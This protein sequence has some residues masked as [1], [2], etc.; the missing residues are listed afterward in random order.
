MITLSAGGWRAAVLPHVG[1]AIGRLDWR[2]RPVFRPAPE[3]TTN[4]LETG[5]FPLVPYANRID[6]GRFRW[7]GRDID[8][9][10]TPGFEPH[11]LHGQGWRE[12]WD[13][14]EVDGASVRLVLR[15]PAGAWPW[16]WAAEQS[17]RLSEAGLRIDLTVT[18]KDAAPMPAGLGLHPY[19]ATAAGD[20]VRL[21][22]TSVWVGATLIPDR[23][24]PPGA[25]LD[26]ADGLE[27][28]AAPF[29][30]HAYD[31]WTGV[32]EIAGDVRTVRLSSAAPVLHVYA[33]P[34]EG[35]VCLEPVSHRPNAVNAPDDARSPMRALQPGETLRLSMSVTA[36]AAQ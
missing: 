34:G 8:L 4:R 17:V 30:D 24:E 20:R 19:F 14:V 6:G 25:V 26:W 11:A 22:A 27:R 21:S 15:T 1:G 2:G 18:N 7:A 16:D 36:E 31:G 3:A 29:V 23:R 10:A 12:P 28:G 5:C 35:F 33:P 32:A 9:G 13:V